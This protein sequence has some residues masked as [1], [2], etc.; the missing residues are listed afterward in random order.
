MGD[1]LLKGRVGVSRQRTRLTTAIC[2]AFRVG[3]NT[4]STGAILQR[5]GRP[6]LID[7]LRQ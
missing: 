6:P 2:V 1:L 3:V 4:N 5:S 7:P